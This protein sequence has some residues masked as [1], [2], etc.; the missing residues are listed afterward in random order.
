MFGG[1]FEPV[2]WL[3]CDGRVL[4]A[5]HPDYEVLA[6]LLG[7][8]YGGNGTTTFGLP[9]LR[10][11]AAL[12]A[13]QGPGLTMRALGAK[14]GSESV[15]LTTDQIPSHNHTPV[16]S[17][18]GG[19]KTTATGNIWAR[20]PSGATA[21]YQSGAPDTDLSSMAVG[22]T[23]SGTAHSNMQ[24]YVPMNYIIAYQ[25]VFPPQA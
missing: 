9:D 24:P 11:R 17:T 5:V 4:S 21:A 15:A 12:G 25:G 10:G 13:G 16:C 14:G 22:Q 6:M 1:N 2:G 7:S 18:S 20:Q 8:T 23:G 3:F 19:N